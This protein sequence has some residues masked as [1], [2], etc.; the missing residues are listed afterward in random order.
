M[1]YHPEVVRPAHTGTLDQCRAGKTWQLWPSSR[2]RERRLP[3]MLVYRSYHH[4]E[5]TGYDCV[6]ARCRD[7]AS[8]DEDGL[9]ERSAVCTAYGGLSV[10]S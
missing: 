8:G 1:I 5:G 9:L 4:R 10:G 6:H 3:G 7:A 2:V